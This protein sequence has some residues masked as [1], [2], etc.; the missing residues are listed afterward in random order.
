MT[1]EDKID[2]LAEE[3]SLNYDHKDCNKDCLG[4]AAYAEAKSQLLNLVREARYDE[5]SKFSYLGGDLASKNQDIEDR[6]TELEDE[7]RKKQS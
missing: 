6:L 7:L 5:L 1:I 4:K 2:E 3:L